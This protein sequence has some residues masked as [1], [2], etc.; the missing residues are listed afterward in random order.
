VTQAA[1]FDPLHTACELLAAADLAQPDAVEPLAGGRNNR[2]WEVVCGPQHY[3]LKQYFWSEQ[4]PRDRQGQE[5]EFLRYLREIG[6]SMGPA[7]L[8]R[9]SELRCSL[10]EFID[11]PSPLESGITSAEVGEAVSFFRQLNAG[12]SRGVSLPP[13]SEACFSME[14]H[15]ETTASRVRRLANIQVVSEAHGAAAKLV[16]D[17]IQPFWEAIRSRVSS[18]AGGRISQV[19]PP[20]ERCLSPS[21]FGFHNALRDEGGHLRFIDFEYAGWDDPAKTIIDFCN[22]PDFLLPDQLARVFRE[23]A[24]ACLSP[25]GWLPERL[26][27]LEPVYQLKWSCICLNGFLPGNTGLSLPGR[28][29]EGQL[30]RA[31]TMANR[32]AESLDLSRGNL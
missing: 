21:D 1:A 10:L 2:V 11:G 6:C 26:V 13:V 12:R 23:G 22:Q 30:A 3:L 27:L 15:L 16:A 4:D 18:L 7:P 20:D 17:M 9:N 5:W 8:A 32:A 28:S 14:S 19:L 31:Q 25:L 29:A 24:L